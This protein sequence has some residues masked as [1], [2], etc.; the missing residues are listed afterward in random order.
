[1][2]TEPRASVVWMDLHGR[3]LAEP[4]YDDT[5]LKCVREFRTPWVVRSP[6]EALYERESAGANF[7]PSGFIFH[8]SRCGST[9]LAN[10]LRNVDRYAVVS[11]P[12]PVNSIV[13]AYNRGLGRTEAL[14]MLRGLVSSF[15]PRP[16]TDRQRLFMK[17]TSWCVMQLELFRQAFPDTPC[18]FLYRHPVEIIVS[19]IRSGRDMAAVPDLFLFSNASP[20]RSMP[21]EEFWARAVG[22]YYR[23]I[24]RQIDDRV[25]LVNY[26][27]LRNGA[28]GR[29]IEYCGLS[30][31]SGD[32]ELMARAFVLHSKNPGA[33][34]FKPDE[35]SKW[36]S[37]SEKTRSMADRYAMP[38]YEALEQIRIRS[39]KFSTTRRVGGLSSPT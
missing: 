35:D 20:V 15:E 19:N 29:I 25:L 38:A 7:T 5:I 37:A 9:L 2:L 4:F 13:C 6:I 14:R 33:R 11:E 36:R 28:L 12:A 10:A 31:E 3:S 34:P 17:L 24:L 26:R 23:V 18:I 39:P 30:L 32:S 22:E 21:P 16:P 1:M 8:A 27:D